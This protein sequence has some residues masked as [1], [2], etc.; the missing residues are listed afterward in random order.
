MDYQVD[1][2]LT[3][4][5]RDPSAP[6]AVEIRGV[7]KNYGA[8]TALK[9]IDLT[10]EKGEFFSLLGP[11]GCGKSTTLA[12]IGGFEAPTRGSVRIAGQEV[13]DVPSY[14]R[15]VNTV[16]Q[17]YALFPHMTVAQNVGFGLKM[18]GVPAAERRTAVRD[19]LALVALEGHE[20]R[21]PT[22][23]SGGQRQRVA[24]ARALVNRPAVLLLDEPLGALDLKLRKQ[25]Q[26]ELISLQRKVGITFIYVTHDQEEALTMSDRIAVMDHGNVLQVGTPEEIYDNPTHRF[27]MEF[28]G[29]PNVLPGA[30]SPPDA[31]DLTGI[32]TMPCRSDP[33]IA[34]GD[35][36][37]L[38]IRPERIRLSRHKPEDAAAF[39]ARIDRIVKVGFVAHYHLEHPSGL[40]LLAYRLNED[41][42]STGDAPFEHGQTV[43]VSWSPS[44]AIAFAT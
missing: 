42:S 17:S 23:L 15:P 28:M 16:F 12:L 19:I 2:E 39:T 20:T 35:S 22:Q 10:I 4:S 9:N 18:S 21:R 14:R 40:A 13:A 26:S 32:G 34:A 44:D 8:V 41:Q 38:M 27:V 7:T 29:S 31:A 36:V 1:D 3:L 11:S 33:S 24:L 5:R 43:H 30:A 6:A 25:M 37:S